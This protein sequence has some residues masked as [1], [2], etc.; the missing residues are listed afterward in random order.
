MLI[1]GELGRQVIFRKVMIDGIQNIKDFDGQPVD[2]E[3]F[4]YKRGVQVTPTLQFVDAE[5]NELVPKM[6]GY[7][8]TELY[9]GYLNNAIGG[10]KEKLANN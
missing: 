1:S 10:S 2:P 7:Q 8:G 9:A 5:G 6:V 3:K 4:A